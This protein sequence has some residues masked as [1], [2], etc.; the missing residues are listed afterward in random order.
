MIPNK[1]YEVQPRSVEPVTDILNNDVYYTDC[2]MSGFKLYVPYSKH[3]HDVIEMDIG[4]KG[5]NCKCDAYVRDGYAFVSPV[6]MR[7]KIKEGME[8][9][10]K[11]DCAHEDEWDDTL[12]EF[13]YFLLDD[14]ENF[15]Y[16]SQ[17]DMHVAQTLNVNDVL[18]VLKSTILSL[19]NWKDD[20]A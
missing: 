1:E 5:I 3:V 11:D 16:P 15:L 13:R 14:I 9:I 19:E 4:V 20:D 2:Y 8:T 7:K 12:S 17:N 10:V 18:D 6:D